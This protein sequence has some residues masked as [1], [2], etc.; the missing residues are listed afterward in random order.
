MTSSGAP[1]LPTEIFLRAPKV[2]LHDHLDG[3]IR[4]QTLLEIAAEVGYDELPAADPA[5]LGAWFVEAAS[6]GSLER[7]LET[8]A[9]TVALMQTAAALHRVARE[10][11]I[12]LAADGVVYAE[13]RFAPELHLTRGL[14]MR[15]VVEAVLAGFAEGTSEAKA[16]AVC[17]RATVWV[18]V[19]RYRS[20][21]PEAAASTNQAPR[22]AGSEE[23][24]LS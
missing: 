4:P 15:E 20:R 2:L 17:I 7:Y 9:H 13:V 21:E 19:S 3:G 5:A 8:F 24:R 18:K 16:A 14:T 1:V 12:D 23:G 22:A 10:C 11:A 6:S